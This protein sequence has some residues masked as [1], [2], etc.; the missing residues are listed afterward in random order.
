MA[1]SI[2][3]YK[4]VSINTEINIMCVFLQ[5][6]LKVKF[7]KSNISTVNKKLK[8]LKLGIDMLRENRD[9]EILVCNKYQP[10]LLDTAVY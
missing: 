4:N 8:L 6:Y 1:F 5:N 2:D 3:F 10:K 7:L 9:F